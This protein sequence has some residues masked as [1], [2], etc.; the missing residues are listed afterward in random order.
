MPRIS[1][2]SSKKQDLLFGL[3]REKTWKSKSLARRRLYFLRVRRKIET[4]I[5]QLAERFHHERVRARDRW[6]L[7]VRVGRKLISHTMARWFTKQFKLNPLEFDKLINV[8]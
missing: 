4:V 7:T 6:H 5:G 8:A 2:I 3:H 1:K